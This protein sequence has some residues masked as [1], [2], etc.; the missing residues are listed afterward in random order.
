MSDF[1]PKVSIVVPV[2][3]GSNYLA[4][5]LE[6]ALAQTYRNTEIIVVDDGSCDDGATRDVAVSYGDR[7]RYVPK[8]NGG[9]S[10]ALNAGIAAM[11]GEYF[12]WLSHDDIYCKDKIELQI[13]YIRQH[14]DAAFLCGGFEKVDIEGNLLSRVLQDDRTLIENG[15]QA[16]SVYIFGCT[17]LIKKTCFDDV[18]GFNEANR[19][20]SD[21]EMWLKIIRK[22]KLHYIDKILCKERIHPEQVGARLSD[23]HEKDRAYFFNSLFANVDINWY[24]DI[25]N[26]KLVTQNEKLS[27][28]Y[29]WMANYAAEVGCM[30]YARRFL[31]ES[32]RI[33]PAN[34]KVLAASTLGL[35]RYRKIVSAIMDLK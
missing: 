19:T 26:K 8:A 21:D 1:C 30:D 24:V 11:T 20:T 10:S 6:S 5:A 7:I 17:T 25:D 18:G 9:V 12:S 28:A 15:R 31:L 3:N 27:E 13:E 23:M 14:R 33:R 32:L 29:F 22:Y 35:C 34:L 16:L 4:D 2:F